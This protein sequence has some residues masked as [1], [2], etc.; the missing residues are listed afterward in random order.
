VDDDGKTI[1]LLSLSLSLSLQSQLSSRR[2]GQCF[3]CL[4]VISVQ[5]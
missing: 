1:F 4:F 5:S 2:L 3:F